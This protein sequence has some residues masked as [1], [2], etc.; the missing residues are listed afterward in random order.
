MPLFFRTAT[1]Q[2]SREPGDRKTMP[3]LSEILFG[4][5]DLVMTPAV[6][7]FAPVA[8]IL[9]RL[10][11]RAPLCRWML[12]KFQVAVVRHHY[13]EPIVFQSDLKQDFGAPRRITGLDLNEAG[14]LTL[15][16]NFTYGEELLAI[17]TEKTS[18]KQF[19]YHNNS[20]ES[21]DAEFLYNMIR[22]FKPG[23]I[24]EIGSGNST[25]M[26][27]LAIEQNRAENPSYCCD[28]IC[29][30]P[31]EQLWLEAIGANVVR[32]TVESCPESMFDAL[33]ENDILF[34]DSSHIIRPQGDVLFEY[35]QILGLLRPN[36]IVHVHDV[37]TPYDY[38]AKWIKRDRWMWNE[39]YLLEAFLSFNNRFEVIAAVNWL[40]HAHRDRL[41]DACPILMREPWREPGSFWFRRKGLQ[42]ELA[43]TF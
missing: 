24:I 5:F 37:F 31:F 7:I 30:E 16:E 11:S 1:C 21:G 39:Q 29:V 12:E 35:L 42:P 40:S 27:R 32:K 14:Q 43:Q 17:P 15:L 13:Y 8:A 10:R 26:A 6:L 25:L 3:S 20:F 18:Q 9:A 36:V 33:V 19:G 23:R 22:H 41:H 38:P 2:K 34:I 28:Q 4:L